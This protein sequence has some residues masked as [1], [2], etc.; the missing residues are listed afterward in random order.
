MQ[1]DYELL[2]P[3]PEEWEDLDADDALDGP[4]IDYA[5]AA[6]IADYYFGSAA[7]FCEDTERPFPEIHDY[8]DY[9]PFLNTC[10]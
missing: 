8:A 6:R 2:D 1:Y 5:L 9:L 10:F 3:L 7:D 4:G